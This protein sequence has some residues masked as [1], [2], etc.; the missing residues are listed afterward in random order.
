MGDEEDG[1]LP[2]SEFGAL[3]EEVMGPRVTCNAALLL[4]LLLL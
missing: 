1:Q 3:H 2:P 4:L